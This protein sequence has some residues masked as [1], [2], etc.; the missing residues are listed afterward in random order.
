M[1]RFNI[2]NLGAAF[3]GAIATLPQAVAYGLISVS[4]LGSEWFAYGITASIF[5]AIIFGILSGILSSNQF[6]V[7][8]PRAI[9]A[10]ILA[11]GVQSGLDRG[12][13]PEQALILSFSGVVI[14]GSMQFLAGSLKLGRMAS[15][16]PVPVLAG[17]VSASALLVIL[18]SLPSA[19]G[20]SEASLQGIF[21]QGNQINQWALLVSSITVISI[22]FFE[23]RIRLF[24]SALLGLL[25]GSLVYYGGVY[26]SELEA[27]N[28]V[29]IFE[30]QQAFSQF[31]ILFHSGDLDLLRQ[32]FDI[33]LVTGSS[34]AL[35]AA[36]DTV[37]SSISLDVKTQQNSD[38]NRDLKSHGMINILTGL[39]G[40]LPGSGTLSRSNAIIAAGAT[41]RSAN[42]GVGLLLFLLLT[43]LYPVVSSLPLWVAAGMLI[44]ISIQAIDKITLLRIW[45]IIMRKIPYRQVVAGD[46]IVTLVV[47]CSALILGLNA[48]VGIGLIIAILLFALSAGR[49]PVRRILPGARLSSKIQRTVQQSQYLEKKGGTISVL[50]LQG[51][52]FFGSCVSLIDTTKSLLSKDTRYLILDL[53]RLSLIDRTGATALISINQLCQKKNAQ[54][55][56][57]CVETE[58]R[59]RTAKSSRVI[60]EVDSD[61]RKTKLSPRWIWL[62]MEA[63]RV[64]SEIG[65]Q[66]VYDDTYTALAVCEDL[67]LAEADLVRHEQI[68][69]I[70]MEST[71]TK[72]LSR[73]DMKSLSKYVNMRRFRAGEY[74]FREKD[75]ADEA[76]FLVKGRVDVLINIPGSS[77]Q[78]RITTLLPGS[79]F[80]EMGILDHAPRSASI[81]VAENALCFSINHHA[82]EK[83]KEDLAEV[84]FILM[85][86]MNYLFSERLRIASSV[87]A[88]LEQ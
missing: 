18:S 1:E 70:V 80:G 8:G 45:Q 58:R 50:E 23:N 24:P 38:A 62:T 21:E 69:T 49:N 46:V 43:L 48:A 36:F 33:T 12:F 37:L 41:K 60:K 59:L 54:L 20:L 52:L 22:L 75:L 86:N 28:T 40:L 81:L 26:Y 31:G 39:L 66:W 11:V 83:L 71:L 76:F 13:S 44:A 7:S 14:A 65:K 30:P 19:L 57:S 2:N 27:A 5:S 67:L 3:V 78:R 88:E 4:P 9:T 42:I 82:I 74:I 34:I 56:L 77:R 47:V 16:L 63:N 10:L 68:D 84:A 35:L 17:F 73:D 25:I 29:G 87:I 79:L 64:F 55:L 32:G 61:R 85:R 53:R 15:Y 6:L 51:S 72:D